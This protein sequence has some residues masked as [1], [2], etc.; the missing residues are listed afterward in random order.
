MIVLWHPPH[1]A[2][3]IS[4]GKSNGTGGWQNVQLLLTLFK[5]T[6]SVNHIQPKQ[7]PKIKLNFN[8][9]CYIVIGFASQTSEL[10]FQKPYDIDL[11]VQQA[12]HPCGLR[13]CKSNFPRIFKGLYQAMTFFSL[14]LSFWLQIPWFYGLESQELEPNARASNSE[15]YGSFLPEIE[16]D[17]N[18]HVK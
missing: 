12:S 16:E 9:H 8:V 18:L 7:S 6:L 14:S 1:T 10:P 15:A 4:M 11:D 2:H 5:W 17:Y 13:L 3:F